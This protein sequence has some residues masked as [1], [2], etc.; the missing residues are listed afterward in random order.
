MPSKMWEFLEV[1]P[2]LA[3]VQAEH[4]MRPKGE[5][6]G[7]YTRAEFSVLARRWQQAIIQWSSM[8]LETL[9]AKLGA[10]AWLF[11]RWFLCRGSQQ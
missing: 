8:F 6:W 5:V 9:L 2:I 4:Q 11:L 3:G 7:K 10:S 1:S